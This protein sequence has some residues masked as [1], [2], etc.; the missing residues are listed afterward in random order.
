MPNRNRDGIAAGEQELHEASLECH[1][2]LLQIRLKQEIA[3]WRHCVSSGILRGSLPPYVV[4]VGQYAIEI[5]NAC[6]LLPWQ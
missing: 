4:S 5:P 1:S 2:R 6:S 3:I